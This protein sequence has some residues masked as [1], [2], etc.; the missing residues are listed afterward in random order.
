MSR[1]LQRTFLSALFA[2]STMP[3]DV[4]P[5]LGAE[6]RRCYGTGSWNW[7]RPQFA[8]T[9]VIVDGARSSEMSPLEFFESFGRK[10]GDRT[11][12]HK[13]Y[14]S[15][16][17][18][19]LKHSMTRAYKSRTVLASWLPAES[20]LHV[21]LAKS[22][23]RW[24]QVANCKEA[25]A[26][27]LLHCWRLHTSHAVSKIHAFIPLHTIVAAFNPVKPTPFGASRL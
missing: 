21:F 27:E 18:Y 26:L 23:L 14:Q 4:T 1:L 15:D 19:V 2:Q 16:R 3:W 25:L 7:N 20:S 9:L 10:E 12:K 6:K 13:V 8:N 24:H 11:F 17:S 5:I 22:H